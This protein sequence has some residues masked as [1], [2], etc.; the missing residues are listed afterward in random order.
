[1]VVEIALQPTYPVLPKAGE[2]QLRIYNG[3][4]CEFNV[5]VGNG[6]PNFVLPSGDFHLENVPVPDERLTF[7][8]TATTSSQGCSGFTQ[9]G[10]LES[11]KANSFYLESNSVIPFEDEPD[12]S[13]Q[14][15]PAVRVLS[16]YQGG[17]TVEL[18]GKDGDNYVYNNTERGDAQASEYSVLVAGRNAGSGFTLKLG[19]VYTFVI[20][21]RATNDYVSFFCSIKVPIGLQKLFR[22]LQP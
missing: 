4:N 13:R 3:R 8:M 1:M 6:I 18:L 22:R 21:E 9:S 10:I 15:R 12:K 20:T 2:S 5:G 14:G 11:G 7:T 19:G 17:I 16:N